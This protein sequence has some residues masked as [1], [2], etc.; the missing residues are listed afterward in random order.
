MI[1]D[2]CSVP[3][4]ADYGVGADGGGLSPDSKSS[5]ASVTQR[6][7]RARQDPSLGHERLEGSGR[8]GVE[9]RPIDL[10]LQAMIG[11]V[12]NGAGAAQPIQLKSLALD[13]AKAHLVKSRGGL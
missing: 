2:F 3:D 10:L 5:L 9:L 1:A 11:L 13:R 4:L 8:R 12:A 6:K 7:K